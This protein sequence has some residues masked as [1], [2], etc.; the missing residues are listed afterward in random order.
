M[1]ARFVRDD[2]PAADL[3]SNFPN[4]SRTATR[5]FYEKQHSLSL[6]GVRLVPSALPTSSM[7]VEDLLRQLGD[8]RQRMRREQARAN[9]ALRRYARSGVRFV[10]LA[11]AQ[12]LTPLGVEQSQLPI[13]LRLE[14]IQ[15]AGIDGAIARARRRA[16]TERDAVLVELAALEQSAIDRIETALALLRHTPGPLI[17]VDTPALLDQACACGAFLNALDALRPA[18]ARTA[19]RRGDLES[20]RRCHGAPSQSRRGETSN[21][22]VA[23]RDAAPGELTLAFALPRLLLL[24]DQCFSRVIEITVAV[25]HAWSETTS[26]VNR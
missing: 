19:R 8:A 6:D 25:E 24:A 20:A 17:D 9:D 13:N 7:W 4:L 22:E 18:I 12:H 21:L 11:L 15:A 26:R 1:S 5:Q 3:F 23:G 16:S 10:N 2:R 14:D